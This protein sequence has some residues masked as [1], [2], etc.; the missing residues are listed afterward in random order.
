MAHSKR[1]FSFFQETLLQEEKEKEK[2]SSVRQRRR[3]DRVILAI[4]PEGGWMEREV[5]ALREKGFQQIDLGSRILRT[6]IA[7][8]LLLSF[9]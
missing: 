9:N 7:V 2:E 4:G 8:S 3:I 5:D 1:L 6:D